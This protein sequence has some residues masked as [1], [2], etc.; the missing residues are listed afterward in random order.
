M[1][2]AHIHPKSDPLSA[3][4]PHAPAALISC[5]NGVCD[6]DAVASAPE[7][8]V[9]ARDRM[10]ARLLKLAREIRTP[11]AYVGYAAFILMGLLK[12]CRPRV[13]ER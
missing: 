2:E 4:V 1:T 13:F 9:A 8:A 12:K 5:S 3:L 10:E 11:R 6:V 7:P